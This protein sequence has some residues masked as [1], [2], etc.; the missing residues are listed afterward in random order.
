MLGFAHTPAICSI[1]IVVDVV[2]LQADADAAEA[3][4]R[5]QLEE[6]EGRIAELEA[7]LAL[8]DMKAADGRGG[9]GGGGGGGAGGAWVG[10]A[11]MRSVQQK[12]ARCAAGGWR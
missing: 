6:V 9:G 3:E 4:C 7:Q 11:F 12:Q 8:G 10:R 2:P 1:L 5:G